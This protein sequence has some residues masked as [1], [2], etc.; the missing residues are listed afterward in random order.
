MLLPMEMEREFEKRE[1]G[2]ER[3]RSFG[4]GPARA[5]FPP[6]CTLSLEPHLLSEDGSVY[7]LGTH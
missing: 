7:P 6:L 4:A 2:G 1:L 5:P 3:G